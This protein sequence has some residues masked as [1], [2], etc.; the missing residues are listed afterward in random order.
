MQK[1]EGV[2]KRIPMLLLSP[3]RRC[4]ILFPSQTGGKGRRRINEFFSPLFSGFISR[5]LRKKGGGGEAPPF[6]SPPFHANLTMY[7]RKEEGMGKRKERHDPF[8]PCCV[9]GSQISRRHQLLGKNG[10]S[11]KYV[12]DSFFHYF[13]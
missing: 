9:W 4:C 12:D 2:L 5:R 7:R 8:L 11:G 3:T 13:S 1:E 6:I 10:F